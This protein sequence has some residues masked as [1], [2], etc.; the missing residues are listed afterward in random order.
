MASM[1]PK[2]D[3]RVMNMNG[4]NVDKLFKRVFQRFHIKGKQYYLCLKNEICSNSV[5]EIPGSPQAV[6]DP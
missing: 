5:L 4:R 3:K 1:Y 2:L 6:P